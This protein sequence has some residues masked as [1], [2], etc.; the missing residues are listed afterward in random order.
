MAT[1]ATIFSC[2]LK[3]PEMVCVFFWVAQVD[4]LPSGLWGN[5]SLS[6]VSHAGV[7]VGGYC[8]CLWFP[9]MCT[10]ASSLPGCI[11]LDAGMCLCASFQ[12]FQGEHTF[13]FSFENLVWCIYSSSKIS[14]ILV[15]VFSEP[16]FTTL[17][18]NWVKQREHVQTQRGS[19]SMGQEPPNLVW[20]LLCET[21]QHRGDG[22]LWS[23]GM[24][25]FVWKPKLDHVKSM[26]ISQE[27]TNVD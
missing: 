7:S 17:Q 6:P 27:S 22:D 19:L 8:S 25:S 12:D 13:K 20:L 15:W 1:V 2:F 4:V 18:W 5:H 9:R 23:W 26:R 10:V 14:G 11:V 3:S 21:Q 16:V 24:Y